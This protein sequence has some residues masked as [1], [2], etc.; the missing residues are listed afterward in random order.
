MDAALSGGLAWQLLAVLIPLKIVATSLT[1]ASGGSGGVFLPSLYIGSV[2][3]GL[4]GTGVHHLL[5]SWSADSGA[6]ALVGMAG[7]LAAATHSPITAMLLLFE[8]TSDYKI[9]LPVMM[10]TTVSTMVGRALKEDSLYT[11]ALRRKGISQ[12]RREDLI[13]R[14]H[15]VGEVMRP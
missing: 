3:G 15:T 1:L 10:V 5:G 6:Y 4:Y 7:L 8:V 14:S 9:I 2:V 12:H 13:M 11:M